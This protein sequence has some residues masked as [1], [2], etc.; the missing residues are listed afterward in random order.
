MTDT[1]SPAAASSDGGT[2]RPPTGRIGAAVDIGSSSM[3]LV[4]AVVRGASVEPILDESVFLGLGEAVEGRGTIGADGTL[5]LVTALRHYADRARAMGA[6]RVTVVSTEPLRRALDA[7]RVVWQAETTA[8][9]AVHVV[10]HEEEALLTLIGATGGRRVEGELLVVDIGGG[11]SEI[12]LVRPGSAPAAFGMRLGAGQLTRQ[13]VRHDPATPDELRALREAART[14]LAIAPPASPRYTVLVGGTAEK[15]LRVA[16][17]AAPDHT[18]TPDAVQR[19]VERLMAEPAATLARRHLL[20]LE[21]ARVL[22][23]GAAIVEAV[24]ERYAIDGAHVSASGLREGIL[25]AGAHAGGG[26]RDRLRE[27]AHGWID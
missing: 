24:F 13:I 6:Q 8:G 12:A 21:R 2:A 18:L 14:H 17:D 15:L 26:W 22:T 7:S 5:A 16:A 19:A 3:H 23:A 20:R 1:A 25:L 9:V 27:L 4:V 10:S 11:S